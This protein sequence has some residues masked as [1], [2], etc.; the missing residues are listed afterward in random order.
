MC[1]R[2]RR[3]AGHRQVAAERRSPA[4]YRVGQEREQRD[5][6]EINGITGDPKEIKLQSEG[7]GREPG[8]R[9]L[10]A[11]NEERVCAILHRKDASPCWG[12]I[13]E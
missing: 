13:I 7:F 3:E 5:P 12:R 11:G 4:R 10:G 2:R 8:G 1:A 6:K 9:A